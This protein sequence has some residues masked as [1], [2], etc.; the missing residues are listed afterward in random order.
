[1]NLLIIGQ[2]MNALSYLVSLYHSRLLTLT[3]SVYSHQPVFRHSQNII[4]TLKY[5]KT[6]QQVVHE[7]NCVIHTL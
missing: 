6:F 2:L 4:N 7:P 3:L 5:N 1:M